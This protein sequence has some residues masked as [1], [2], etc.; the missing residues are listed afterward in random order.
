LIGSSAGEGA[1]S[2]GRALTGL[3][4]ERLRN[5]EAGVRVQARNFYARVQG[6]HADLMDPIDRRT[7][8]FPAGSAPDT[9]AGLTVTPIPQTPE[10]RAADV[11]TLA[12]ALDSRALK[13]FVNDG[14]YRYYGVESIAEHRLTSAWMMRANYWFLH[15]RQLNPNR[16]VRRLPPQQGR[17]ALLHNAGRGFWMEVRGTLTGR[18]DRLSGGDLDDERIGASRSRQDIANFFGS[19]LAAPWVANGIFTP[20]GETLAQIQ[21][22]VL[23]GAA[24]ATT[25]VPLYRSTAGWVR[26]DVL[27]GFKVGERTTV[28]AGIEN[29]LDQGYRVHGSGVDGV[30]V[31]ASVRIRYSF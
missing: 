19:A 7:L 27:G 20:T 2:I 5:F 22:R 11:V 25:R 21:E 24:S 15:G 17:L 23:P 6:F 9:L 30:G 18:Q 12:T 29:L 8:L 10:Q 26:V 28:Y 4:P 3:S 14:Q 13:A 1:T 31:N 16:Y